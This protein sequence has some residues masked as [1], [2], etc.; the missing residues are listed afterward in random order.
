MALK[1]ADLVR[2]S[3]FPY[4]NI[5]KIVLGCKCVVLKCEVRI[6]RVTAYLT[7]QVFLMNSF[8]VAP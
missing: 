1:N 8:P 5:D 2:V 7:E 4:I 3:C 6:V